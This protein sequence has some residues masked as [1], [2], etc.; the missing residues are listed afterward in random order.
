LSPGIPGWCQRRRARLSYPERV[1][2]RGS[3]GTPRAC[4]WPRPQT[5]GTTPAQEH[6]PSD[7]RERI[8]S[9][10]A[11]AAGIDPRSTAASRLSLPRRQWQGRLRAA[12]VSRGAGKDERRGWQR[13][14]TRLG[15]GGSDLPAPRNRAR[16]QAGQH[17]KGA[18]QPK[19]LLSLASHRGDPSTVARQFL[20][21]VPKVATEFAQP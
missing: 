14:R 18:A 9:A 19:A 12:A 5:G 10:A 4:P 2:S 17:L 15:L 20:R 1:Y 13:K 11:R 7:W 6:A 16:R 8:D 21:I 3:H